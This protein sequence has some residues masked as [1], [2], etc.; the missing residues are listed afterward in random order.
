MMPNSYFCEGI[1]IPT[2]S[3]YWDR[4]VLENSVDPDQTGPEGI[5]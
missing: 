1:S 4:Q 5:V 3:K 2:E